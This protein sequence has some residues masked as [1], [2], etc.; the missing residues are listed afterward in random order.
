MRHVRQIYPGITRAAVEM[1]YDNGGV[2]RDRS[3][4]TVVRQLARFMD[5]IGIEPWQLRDI[6][7]WLTDLSEDD[8]LTAVAGEETEML[9]LMRKG[10][11]FA[12]KLLCD[13][14]E[15]GIP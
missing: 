11:P 4:A 8:I 14:F 7:R 1:A 2:N 12:H 9:E 3:E 13:I 15:A 6:D 10:P 5:G